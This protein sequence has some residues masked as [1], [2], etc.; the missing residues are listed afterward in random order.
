MHLLV[1]MN[2]ENL[3]GGVLMKKILFALLI[4]SAL[5]MSITGCKTTTVEEN[6]PFSPVMTFSVTEEK[7]SKT[8]EPYMLDQCRNLCGDGYCNE[9]RCIEKGD[10][11]YGSQED[12]K[13]EDECNSV[14]SSCPEDEYNC[15]QDCAW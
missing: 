15:P 5:L 1:F 14:T 3:Y 2:N 10:A 13:Y 11:H 7:D 12:V 4:L 9:Y 6:E 8:I